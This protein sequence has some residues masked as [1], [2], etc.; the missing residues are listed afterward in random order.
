[1]RVIDGNERSELFGDRFKKICPM[2]LVNIRK[3]G[4]ALM[5]LAVGGAALGQAPFSLQQCVDTALAHNAEL[6]IGRNQVE[7]GEQRLMEAKANRLPKLTANGDY[8]WSIELPYQFMPLSTFNPMAPEGQFKEVQFGV[9]HNINAN[10]QLALPLYNPQLFG[11]IRTAGVAA[12][13]QA[14][15]LR[16]TGEQVVQEVSTLYYNAQVL[17]HQLAYLY[18]NAVNTEKLL[19]NMRLLRAQL[20]A[21]GTDVGRVELQAEQLATQ[22]GQVASRYAQVLD[23]LKLAMGLPLDHDLHIDHAI[24]LGQDADY[25]PATTVEHRLAE[26]QTALVRSEL[27][28]LD[29]SR[30]LPSV[31]LMGSYG[32][33]G[34]GYDKPPN[35]FLKFHP[36]SMA[37][38]QVSWPLFSGTVINRKMAGKRLELHN[39][40]LQL[41]L[42]DEKQALRTATAQRQRELARSTVANTLEQV[43]LAQRIYE[44][45]LLQQAQ[46]TASLT[47]V[48]LA[49]NALRAAQQ[50][51]LAALVDYLKADLELKAATGN[52]MQTNN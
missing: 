10:V 24:V 11:G 27:G 48:L 4:L 41:K 31:N 30:Y 26:T 46:G 32:T 16:K 21:T 51:Q 15:Q 14:L 47:E 23:A 45:T 50:D 3:H 35:D 39:G 17:H 20:L 7:M 9:P 5:L 38:L 42:L 34:F 29:R 19:R 40:E 12:E 8:R 37:G 36:V 22:R 52:L 44:Q 2:M 6:M 49:D 13:L 28:T 25:L 18:S 33:M 1:M 43:D